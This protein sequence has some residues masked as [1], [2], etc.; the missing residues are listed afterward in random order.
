MNSL[1]KVLNFNASNEFVIETINN[2]IINNNNIIIVCLN[3][4]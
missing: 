4:Y 3:E 2:Y 1:S